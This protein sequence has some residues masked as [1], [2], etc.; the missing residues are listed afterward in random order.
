ME[1]TQDIASYIQ[2]ESGNY[3]VINKSIRKQ[4]NT[5]LLIF[6]IEYTYEASEV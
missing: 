4:N 1:P 6:H 2:V 3:S 5:G